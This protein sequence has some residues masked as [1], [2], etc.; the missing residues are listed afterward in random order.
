MRTVTGFIF[1]NRARKPYQTT[2][3]GKN[4]MEMQFDRPNQI[5][6]VDLLN[7]HTVWMQT[8]WPLKSLDQHILLVRLTKCVI[9]IS[10]LQILSGSV[11]ESFSYFLK[12]NCWIDWE[13]SFYF[14]EPYWRICC[15]T[16]QVLASDITYVWA[17]DSNFQFQKIKSEYYSNSII[18]KELLTS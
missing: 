9:L 12:W 4:S 5:N 10:G 6:M 18:H 3:W 14:M 16:Q 7:E 13:Q 15:D 8:L 2:G 11:S 17:E 1:N